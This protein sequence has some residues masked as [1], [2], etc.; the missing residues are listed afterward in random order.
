VKARSRL[1]RQLQ[2]VPGLTLPASAMG[3]YYLREEDLVF[4]G[5]FCTHVSYAF[6][7]RHHHFLPMLNNDTLLQVELQCNCNSNL[8]PVL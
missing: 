5:M 6:L 7:L 2:K 4:A 1:N 3:V 8:N